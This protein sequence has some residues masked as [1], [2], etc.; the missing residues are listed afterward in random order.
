MFRDIYMLCKPTHGLLFEAI[1]TWLARWLNYDLHH[2]AKALSKGARMRIKFQN[3]LKEIK[4]I[5]ITYHSG[6]R[7]DFSMKLYNWS[8]V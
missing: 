6:R 4:N 2:D 5:S 3:S 1:E 8:S 7:S